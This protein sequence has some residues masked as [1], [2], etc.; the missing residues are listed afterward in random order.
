MFRGVVIRTIVGAVGPRRS[1]FREMLIIFFEHEGFRRNPL[2]EGEAA[3]T[4]W[5]PHALLAHFSRER[6]P[7]WTI[8]ALYAMPYGELHHYLCLRRLPVP[9]GEP[10]WQRSV[11]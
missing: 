11:H 6:A 7:C 3:Q 9:D 5:P 4:H 8:G 10:A 2:L 1:A